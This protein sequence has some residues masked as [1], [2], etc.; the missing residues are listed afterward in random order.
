M[1]DTDETPV[2]LT[3]GAWHGAWCW[4]RVVTSLAKRG[5]NA[6]PVELMGFGGLSGASPL[7]RRARPFDPLAFATE[8]SGVADVT[9]DLAADALIS[10]LRDVGAGRPALVVAHSLGGVV[11][12]AAAERAPGNKAALS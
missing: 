6:V 9:V 7:A 4:A 1:T 5:I 11:V 3:N 8:P 10:D 2:V 12:T